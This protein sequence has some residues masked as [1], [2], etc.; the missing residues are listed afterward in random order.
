[1]SDVLI[2]TQ[3]KSYVPRIIEYY[4][5]YVFCDLEAR[6]PFPCYAK[7]EESAESGSSPPSTSTSSSTSLHGRLGLS[8]VE[9]SRGCRG[10]RGPGL[11]LIR[12]VL[13]S[14]EDFIEWVRWRSPLP[15]A[16]ARVYWLGREE[17]KT[18]DADDNEEQEEEGQ[19]KKEA[20]GGDKNSLASP[21]PVSA[22]KSEDEKE[23]EEGREGD[24]G[25]FAT[26]SAS[27]S[28]E[29]ARQILSRFSSP[30]PPETPVRIMAVPKSLQ[31]SLIDALAGAGWPLEPRAAG[32]AERGLFVVAAALDGLDEL[33]ESERTRHDPPLPSPRYRAA[34]VR[35]SAV[36]ADTTEQRQ[37]GQRAC[38]AEWKLSEA[39][40][41][42][43]L[44][45]G[46]GG[47]GEAEGSAPGGAA[48]RALDVGAS[49]GGWTRHLALSL[50]AA[51]VVALDPAELDADVSALPNVSHLRLLSH[52]PGAL[53]AARA[54]LL[55]AGVGGPGAEAAAEAR[56][57]TLLT[58]DANDTPA[59]AARCILPLLPL[60]SPGALVV[61]TL[62][63]RYPGRDK[64]FATRAAMDELGPRGL[65]LVDSRWLM[66]NTMCE[67]TLVLRRK[68]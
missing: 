49:P 27:T 55:R 20:T 56:P 32:A 44:E 35:A 12:D 18:G 46:G 14:P 16:V 4:E 57:A 10:G 37:V 11:V 58:C 48:I 9:L 38:R 7:P 64:D 26:F 59:K 33:P 67:R 54:A 39:L 53:E 50:R 42:L 17:R 63:L 47:D 61:L 60:L 31:I 41:G 36:L 6:K 29:L 34:L 45:G 19:E 25:A 40:A 23:D 65:E 68:G 3:N 22:A 28:A 2:Q 1:M 5:R 21:S 8:A 51:R 66:A 52:A 62:K 13:A 43:G 30:P 15:R 24:S